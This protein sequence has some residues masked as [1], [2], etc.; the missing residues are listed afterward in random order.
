MGQVLNLPLR[1][2]NYIFFYG[3]VGTLILAGIWGVFFAQID[4]L[5]LLNIQIN[6]LP[7]VAA[8]NLL[9]QY[10]FLRAI[11]F[12]F[13]LFAFVFREQIYFDRI[14]NRLFLS[15]MTFGIVARLIATILDGPSALIMYLFALFEIIGIVIIFLSTR[16]TLN[17]ATPE[18]LKD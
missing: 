13:G 8:A 12:G 10:R 15:V 5:L 17:Q 2:A 1:W 11:E 9:S 6:Q 4:I 7:P 16:L 3:Y 14:Y 18:H